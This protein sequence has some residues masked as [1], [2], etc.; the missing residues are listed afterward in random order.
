MSAHSRW[1]VAAKAA[2][3]VAFTLS[4]LALSLWFALGS[5]PLHAVPCGGTP[6]DPSDG[7]VSPGGPDGPAQPAIPADPGAGPDQCTDL[8]DTGTGDPP[9]PT[10]DPPTTDGL[11]ATGD[12]PP[13]PSDPPPPDDDPAVADPP[14]DGGPAPA[15]GD[16]PPAP[17]DPPPLGD[18]PAVADSP[19]APDP[20]DQE[21]SPEGALVVEP[22]APAPRGRRKANRPPRSPALGTHPPAI[23]RCC[24][25]RRCRTGGAGV[26]LTSL[27]AP[28]A[29]ARLPGP[30]RRRCPLGRPRRSSQTASAASA[31]RSAPRARAADRRAVP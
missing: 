2:L 7:A 6:T 21:P 30:L 28:W 26:W 24:R 25:P 19:I 11:P 9:A 12:D 4:I 8:G 29:R 15:T 14:T 5:R 18:D 13:A 3:S 31:L 23:R 16:N 10:E 20:G 17:A 27:G 1:R 22:P